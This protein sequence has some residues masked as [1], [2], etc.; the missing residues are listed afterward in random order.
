VADR[1][2]THPH[3][4]RRP[5]ASAEKAFWRSKVNLGENLKRRDLAGGVSDERSD[6]RT[7]F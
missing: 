7:G 3:R 6:I 4:A 2:A 1:R 5:G